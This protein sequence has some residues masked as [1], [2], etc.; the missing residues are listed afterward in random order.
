[1]TTLITI[2]HI[3]VC[4]ALIVIV[5]FQTGK[6]ADIGATFGGGSSQ[7]LFGSSG[8]ATFMTKLT[9]VAAVVFMLTS[10][11]L[12]YKYSHRAGESVVMKSDVPAPEAMPE[13]LP[14]GAPQAGENAAA[15]R[16]P[17]AAADQ[18]APT[19]KASPREDAPPPDS[20]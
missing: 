12:A 13:A 5:L 18:P 17:E 6:G 14:D 19:D 16:S 2:I 20:Q 8:G 15:D 3:V 1:M 4:I 9:T 10:L 11:G 7:T